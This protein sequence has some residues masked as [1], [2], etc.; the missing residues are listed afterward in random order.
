MWNYWFLWTGKNVL[1]TMFLGFIWLFLQ[2]DPS[3]PPFP[4]GIM[5]MNVCV[6]ACFYGRIIYRCAHCFVVIHMY[7][8]LRMSTCAPHILS[9]TLT[10]VQLETWQVDTHTFGDKERQYREAYKYLM[11]SDWLNKPVEYRSTGNAK[12]R[13]CRRAESS[14]SKPKCSGR[15]WWTKLSST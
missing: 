12:A 14:K 8:V 7:I 9:K 10:Q 1:S 13:P 4:H 5:T 3:L 2:L 15:R 11:E 6:C